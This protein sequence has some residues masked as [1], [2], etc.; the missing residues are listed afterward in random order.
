[1]KSILIAT[2]TVLSAVATARAETNS[3]AELVNS[4]VFTCA[5]VGARS[6]HMRLTVANGQFNTVTPEG[7]AAE[8][9]RQQNAFYGIGEALLQDGP[10]P[11]A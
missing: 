2:V 10:F 5:E 11:L 6:H 3:N 7:A 4:D 8:V 9:V 1:M